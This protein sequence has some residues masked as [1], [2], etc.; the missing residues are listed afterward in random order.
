MNV[1]VAREHSSGRAT[2]RALS[3]SFWLPHKRARTHAPEAVVQDEGR[4]QRW[5]RLVARVHH[6]PVRLR[7]T[8]EHVEMAPRQVSE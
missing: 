1:R 7:P 3:T 5:V 4:R 6:Q 2:I 8:S